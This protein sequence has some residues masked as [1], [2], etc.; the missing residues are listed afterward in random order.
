M[1]KYL[2]HNRADGDIEV[3]LPAAYTVRGSDIQF[4]IAKSFARDLGVYLK[5]PAGLGKIP[6]IAGLIHRNLA[7]IVEIE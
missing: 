4:I 5:D 6:R 2:L 1:S 7:E 3:I